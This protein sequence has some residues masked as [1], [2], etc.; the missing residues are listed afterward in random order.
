M[1]DKQLIIDA[2]EKAIKDTDIFLVDVNITP[3]N[4]VTVEIDNPTGSTSTP[5]RI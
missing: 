2:V 5:V 4:K 3:D 1:I